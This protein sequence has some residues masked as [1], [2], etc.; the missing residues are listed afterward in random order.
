MRQLLALV[1][2]DDQKLAQGLA[3]ALQYCGFEV[4][5]ISDA[6]QAMTTIQTLKPD[7]VTLDVHMPNI[8]GVEILQSIRQNNELAH[9]SVIITTGMVRMLEDRTINE[10]ADAIL[11]KPL[12]LT[13]F[14]SHARRFAE[15]Q[16][17][18]EMLQVTPPS[19]SDGNDTAASNSEA[20]Q[21]Q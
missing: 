16:R 10:M 20:S 3:I 13:K 17:T 7:V 12:D 4:T 9:I 19:Q 2:D 18:R 21:D 1:V 5:H 15:R 11:L 14:T 6:T 8:S